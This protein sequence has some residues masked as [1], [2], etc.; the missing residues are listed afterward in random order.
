[1]ILW[2]ALASHAEPAPASVKAKLLTAATGVAGAILALQV[3]MSDAL[4]AAPRGATAIRQVLPTR[5]LWWPFLAALSLMAVPIL[6]LAWRLRRPP[7][8]NLSAAA[9]GTDFPAEVASH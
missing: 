1:M 4:A 2:G 5:F 7:S 8:G 9:P 6:H 3:F